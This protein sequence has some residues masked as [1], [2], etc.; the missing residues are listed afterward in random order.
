MSVD[1]SNEIRSRVEKVTSEYDLSQSKYTKEDIADM[2]EQLVES[3]A[4]PIDK[5]EESV[6]RT[7][8]APRIQA[9][10]NP[11]TIGDGKTSGAGQNNGESSSM[12]TDSFLKKHDNTSYSNANLHSIDGTEYRVGTRIGC[13]KEGCVYKITNSDGV[14]KIFNTDRLSDGA[15]ENKIEC[16]IRNHPQDVVEDDWD[17]M[18]FAWPEQLLYSDGVFVGYLMPEV[19][20]DSMQ[21]L[22]SYMRSELPSGTRFSQEQVDLA[23]RLC[24][25]VQL[26]HKQGYAIGD[27]NYQNIFIDEKCQ[28]TFIDCDSFSVQSETGDEY[29]SNT[30]FQQTVPPEGRPSTSIAHVQMADNFNLASWLFRILV[31]DE[32]YYNPFQA[33][34]DLAAFGRLDEMMEKNP[35]PYWNPKNGLIEPI[36]YDSQ[37]DVP[38]YRLPIQIQFLFESVFLSGKYHPYKRPS[39]GVWMVVLANYRYD[40]VSDQNGL[41][42]G[43]RR[44]AQHD[45][46]PICRVASGGSYDLRAIYTNRE[47][48]QSIASVK[49][50]VDQSIQVVGKVVSTS[51]LTEFDRNGEAGFVSNV[52]IESMDGNSQLQLTFWDRLGVVA[53]RSLHPGIGICVSGDILNDDFDGN[54]WDKQVF[55]DDFEVIERAD[56]CDSINNLSVGESSPHVRGEIIGSAAPR[57]VNSG[58]SLVQN[59]VIADSTGHISVT[60]WGDMADRVRYIPAGTTV[61]FVDGV[62][63]KSDSGRPQIKMSENEGNRHPDQSERFPPIVSNIDTRPRINPDSI[64]KLREGDIQDVFGVIQSVGEIEEYSDT[65]KRDVTFSDETADIQVSMWGQSTAVDIEVGDEILIT[66]V[67]VDSWRGQ[68]C[69]ASTKYTSVICTDDEFVL[70]GN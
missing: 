60:L 56:Y 15:V 58:E 40:G 70:V 25:I 59:L 44:T 8:D 57:E 35:F 65:R 53:A 32:S 13:G 67:E 66:N 46:L 20:T 28:V 7:I 55:V 43:S 47:D 39:P 19:D 45:S 3:Y 51:S 26:V 50:K 36:G 18:L 63:T 38:Y 9:N 27:F 37:N 54:E 2:F 12:P 22:K 52:I 49:Q 11:F 5:A 34:G 14:A 42:K 16:M 62:I 31:R 17:A 29:H 64:I 61:E 69:Y 6:H 48:V 23:Y 24:K 4:V 68:C 1:D 10:S 30:M 41:Y 21:T 33:G